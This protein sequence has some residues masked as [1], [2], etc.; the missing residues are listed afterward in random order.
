MSNYSFSNYI[1]AFDEINALT[2]TS[3][4]TK[5]DKDKDTDSRV[6]RIADDVLSMLIMAYRWGVEAT[7]DMLGY[8]ASVDT[9]LMYATIFAVIDGKTF[10]DRV[11]AHVRAGDLSG[12]QTLTE[13]EYHRVYNQA[14]KD[15][16]DDIKSE[17]GLKVTKKWRTVGD[18]KVRETHEYLEGMEV[19]L[20][21]DFYTYDGDHASC[22]GG[23][24]K[25]ENNVHC[26]CVTEYKI[27][28]SQV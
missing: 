7:E 12:L 6:E 5:S 14:G 24:T 10:E 21:E 2:S 18:N 28:T 1:L 17:S 27:D 23:F 9:D 16:A 20:N 22:P 11:A 15:A 26:R 4:N 8:S 13:S 19:G 3:Y 25:P